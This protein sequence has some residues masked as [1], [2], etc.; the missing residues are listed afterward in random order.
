MENNIYFSNISKSFDGKIVLDNLSHGF[1]LNQVHVI[2]GK[3]G[4]GKSVLLKLIYQLIKNDDGSINLSSN[5]KYA[6]IVSSSDLITEIKKA[7]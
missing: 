4:M 2:L 1:K 6:D 5:A 7:N 3:S